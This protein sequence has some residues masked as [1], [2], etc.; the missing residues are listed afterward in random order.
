MI[1]TSHAGHIGTKLDEAET[2]GTNAAA[3]LDVIHQQSKETVSEP[4]TS[5]V[6]SILTKFDRTL[7]IHEAKDQID[8]LIH[9]AFPTLDVCDRRFLCRI[10]KKL[11]CQFCA[12][13]SIAVS[14]LIG[15]PGIN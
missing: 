15:V 8:T 4:Y 6:A 1:V 11:G 2:A 3:V 5:S 7:I 13:E 10:A 12:K 14:A 9:P